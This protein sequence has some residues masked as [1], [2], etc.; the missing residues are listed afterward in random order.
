LA[1]LDRPLTGGLTSRYLS[2]TSGDL[3]QALQLYEKNV[4]V[5]KALFGILHGLEITVRNRLLHALSTDIGVAD[6][7][8]QGLALPFPSFPQLAFTADSFL[9]GKSVIGQYR[10]P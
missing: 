5:S 6:W 4:A 10:C 3:D 8:Q 9:I 7:Y 1:D 2:A